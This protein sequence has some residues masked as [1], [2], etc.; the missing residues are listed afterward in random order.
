MICRT[1]RRS[2]WVVSPF[3]VSLLLGCATAEPSGETKPAIQDEVVCL[4]NG[5]DI[6]RSDV[7]A[8]KQ[9]FLIGANFHRSGGEAEQQAMRRRALQSLIDEELEYQDARQRGIAVD[10][11]EIAREYKRLTDRYGGREASRARNARS[12]IKLKE[13]MTAL[14]RDFLIARVTESVANARRD[15]SEEELRRY[16]AEHADMFQLPRRAEVRQILIYMPPLERD[17][18]DW[19]RAFDEAEALRARV[20]T[21]ESFAALAAENSQAPEDEAANGGLIGIVHPGQLEEPLDA[22]LWSLQPG[23]VSEPIR[24]FKGVYLLRVEQSIDARPLTY[25][26]VEERLE[27]RLRNKHRE[28]ALDDWRDSLR[29]HAEIEIVDPS[30][31][32][33]S[34]G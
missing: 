19:K 22:A 1:R 15:V 6:R 34:D 7:Q 30:L 3:F 14:E 13:K 5:V 17:P 31:A 29:E 27:K 10:R 25:D 2:R 32:P 9:K 12:G 8:R 11:E 26:E 24:A 20:A 33:A 23:E 16:F 28:Q 4:V 18:D 21:G